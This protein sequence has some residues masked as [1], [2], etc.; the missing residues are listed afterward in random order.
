M[1]H[2]R[3]SISIMSWNIQDS[4]G[5]QTN[6]F[7]VDEFLNLFS[8]YSIVCMQE[9]KSQI[10]IEG[11][12]SYNSNRKGSRSGGVCIL[13]K[14]HLRK[15]ISLVP[16]PES[17]DIVSIKLDKHFF[18][19]DFDLYLVCFYVSPATSSYVKNNPDYSK[20]TRRLKQKGEIMLCGDANSRTASLPDYISGHNS[21]HDIY[22]DVGFEP[23]SPEARNNCDRSTVAPHTQHFLDFVLNNQLKI[24]NGR[25]LGDSIGKYTCHKWNGSSVV[26]YFVASSWVRD[27]VYSLCV[28][29]LNSYSDHC[30]LILKMITS[31]PISVNLTNLIIESSAMPNRYKWDSKTSPTLFNDAL[32]SPEIL[33][34]LNHIIDHSYEHDME[35]NNNITNDFISC[36]N[37]A[38][39][40]TLKESKK[41]KK[42]PHKRWFDKDCRLS[43][44]NLNRLANRLS[45][46]VGNNTLRTTYYTERNKHSRLI[47]T[48]KHNFLDKLNKAIEEGHV[49]NWQ[50]FK[51][52]KHQHEN[53]PLLDKHDLLSF[54]EFF[55]D[56]YKKPEENTALNNTSAEFP[57]SNLYPNSNS[58]SVSSKEG[59]LNKEIS[60]NEIE[61]AIK[62][63]KKGKSCSVDLISNEMLQSL[64]PTGLSA[65][66]KTFNHCLTSGKYPWHTSIITPIYKSGN[67]FSPDNYRAI[68]VGSC[69]G[70]LFSSILLERLLLFKE[71][72]CADPKEQLGFQKGAQTNDHVLTLK[73]VID[74]YTKKKRVRLYTCFVD[75]KKAFDTV[76]RDLLLHKIVHLGISGNYFHVLSDMYNK[77]IAKIKISNLLSPEIKVLRGTEQGHPLSPDLFKLFIEELS[78]LLKPTNDA[79]YPNLSSTFVSHLLWADDLVLLALDKAGLQAN[80]NILYRFCQKMGLEINNKKTKIVTFC[81]TRQK[82]L[83]ETFMLGDNIIEHTNRYCYLGIIFDQNGSF[84]AANTELRSK[85]LRALYSLKNNIQKDSL[86]FKSKSILFDTLVKPVLLYGCQIIAPHN[87][88]MNYLSNLNDQTSPEHFLKYISQDHYEK[89]HLKFIK[90]NLSVHQKASNV[91]SW[92][93]SGRYPLFFEAIKLSIDY[94]KRVQN[95]FDNSDGSLLAASFRVQRD[96]GLD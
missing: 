6:K 15:G 57:H 28:Q 94:F 33:P 32:D 61:R 64:N 56:L 8:K 87:K 31:K 4:V 26:D 80:I 88:T 43:K 92:G 22:N 19:L 96:L 16:C 30:P 37:K 62:N 72:Y 21:S 36:L 84:S 58:G 49:L 52:L 41:P 11:Y 40:L 75:L 63:L 17:D 2:D 79:L 27:M 9:T 85:A 7:E 95:C 77:S 50:K 90:W 10:K 68:A 35:A 78:S 42:L 89:F 23:D 39:E 67:P 82:P 38:A 3:N 76:S 5:D 66:T 65:L 13:A 12:V 86:S 93:D 81:P 60:I 83:L 74:K 44:R 47:K 25:T 55:A 14:N 24:L 51:Q 45:R 69:M 1:T 46:N 59:I 48:K 73:T 91:G 29:N 20:I 53:S 54:Y 34:K 71:L 70:K 18:K